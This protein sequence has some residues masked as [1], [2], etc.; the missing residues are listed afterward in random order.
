ML[1]P[2]QKLD[3]AGAALYLGTVKPKTLEKWRVIGGGP[4]YI[5]TGRAVVYQVSDLDAWLEARKFASTS[6]YPGEAA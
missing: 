5:K 1:Q 3:T 4:A 6:E 2:H